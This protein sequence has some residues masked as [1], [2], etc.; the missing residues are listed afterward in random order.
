M[1]FSSF[2]KNQRKHL[3][4]KKVVFFYYYGPSCSKRFLGAW[5]IGQ[6]NRDKSIDKLSLTTDVKNAHDK[7]NLNDQFSTF[8]NDDE[9]LPRPK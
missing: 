6:I 3:I 1:S 7:Q 9:K 8:F 2:L 4:F 5:L